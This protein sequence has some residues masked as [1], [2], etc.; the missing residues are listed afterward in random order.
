LPSTAIA[1]PLDG[2]QNSFLTVSYSAWPTKARPAT[3]S[4]TM[5]I[6]MANIMNGKVKQGFL[7]L[8]ARAPRS[9][10]TIEN[11]PARIARIPN[12]ATGDGNV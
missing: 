4:M 3:I 12:R 2:V 8:A 11:N 1:V 10:V 7:H 5:H 9:P 6:I